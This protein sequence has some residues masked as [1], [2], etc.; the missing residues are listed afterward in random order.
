MKNGAEG[1]SATIPA[2]YTDSPFPLQYFF[3]LR[4]GASWLYPSLGT[5]F[6]NQPY[7]FVKPS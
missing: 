4:A 6:C 7:F 3:E 5:N 2:V 1:W